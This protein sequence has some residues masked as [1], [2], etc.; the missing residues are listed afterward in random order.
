MSH[1]TL[2]DRIK[3]EMCLNAGMK[4]NKIADEVGKNRST[5]SREIR[6]HAI[7]VDKGAAYRIKNRCIYRTTV[8][9]THLT[10][11]TTPYV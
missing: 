8:S 4:L 9:Y 7:Q 1:L 6:S 11:P 10:L 3:I 5:I 2:S